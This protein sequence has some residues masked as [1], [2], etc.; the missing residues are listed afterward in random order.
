[1]DR[2]PIPALAMAIFILGATGAYGDGS[3][4]EKAYLSR[5]EGKWNATG[6]VRENAQASTKQVSCRLDGTNAGNS[7]AIRGTCRAHGI[8]TREI[9]VDLEFN[10]DTGRYTG[11]YIG[12]SAGPVRLSGT[13]S[14]TVLTLNATWPKPVNGDRSAT[15]VIRNPGPGRFTFLVIDKVD[16]SGPIET[17]TNLNVAAL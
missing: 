3:D 11:V 17:M 6:K 13:R 16:G 9:G 5:F 1:M 15:M 7:A 8:F 4:G 12:S 10:S 14:G 2:K